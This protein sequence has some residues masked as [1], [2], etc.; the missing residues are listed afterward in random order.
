MASPSK[1]APMAGDAKNKSSSSDRAQ[2]TYTD[3]SVAA[4]VSENNCSWGSAWTDYDGDGYID[5]FTVGH[6]LSPHI[7]ICQLWHNNGN[8]TFS[9]VT[10][11]AGLIELDGDAHGPCWADLDNDGRPDLYVAKGGSKH[12]NSI[13]EN[14]L[15]RNNGDGTFTDIS[16]A[17]NVVGFNS[18]SRGSYAIDYDNDSNLDVFVASFFKNGGGPNLLY[19]NDGQFQFSEV[20]ATSGLG[21]GGIF[22]R[23]AAWTDFDGD[24]FLDVFIARTGGLY[25]N[26]GDGTFEDVTV[27][28]GITTSSF[29]Q[30]GTWGDYDNDGYPDLYV[31]MGD[32][33][34][35]PTNTDTFVGILYHNNG[36]GTFTDVTTATGA[37]NANGALGATWG[38]YDNDGNL[39]L[40]IVNTV[41]QPA[42]P[43]RLFRNNG[44]STFTDVAARAGV[45]A[46]AGGRGSDA[47][48]IDFNN[49]GLLDL[50]VC[51]GAGSSFGPYLLFQNNGGT[52]NGWLKV[53]LV[54]TVSNHDGVGAKLTLT[55]GG[56]TQHRQYVGQHYLAQDRIPVH[57]GLGHAS[58]IDSL[59]IQW[60]SGIVQELDNLAINQMITVVEQ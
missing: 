23:T 1:A 6:L 41:T 17:S 19:H 12:I 15:W 33:D 7:S 21:R 35:G 44:N 57:F 25:R 13:N 42:V 39:D 28:A 8:G 26:R 59:V 18:H 9:N 24:G 51:N 5:F 49:D 20:G 54:G 40:Y 48:F 53:Q 37:V 52:I 31:T 45:G 55:A 29:A 50:F 16:E 56:K 32:P 30:A 3:I 38:D 27:A 58:T 22:N 47:T 14:D 11:D 43:N 46:K 2:V 10:S 36:N 60:P 34:E 4:G